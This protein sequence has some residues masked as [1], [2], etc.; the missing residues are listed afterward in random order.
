M[1]KIAATNGALA[2][3]P[4]AAPSSL[5]KTLGIRVRDARARHGMTRRMLA[6]DSRISERYLAELESGRGNLSIVLLKRLAAAIDVP[7]TELVDEGPRPPAE[8]L[9]LTQRLRRLTPD[10]LIQAA[11]LI[12]NRFGRSS[13]RLDR[14]ALVGLRGA[15]KTTLGKLL[16]T[17]L[18][19]EFVELSHAI[20]REAS[21]PLAEIFEF[22]GQAAYR[23]YEL[24][25]LES[26]VSGRRGIVLAA[27]GGLVAEAAS[28]ER[29]LDACYTVWVQASPQ[30]HWD[31]VLN[32]GDYRVR[33][34]TRDSEALADMRRILAQRESLYRMADARLD[35][36]SK[37]IS[38]ALKELV[39]LV[40]KRA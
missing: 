26:V 2:E 9:M 4:D 24:R 3:V 16:A 28:L 14:I 23:R 12:T 15:G 10:E 17:Q 40:A 20:E 22:G 1:R 19:W 13:N 39:K 37:T 5:L 34:G 30:E 31:R 8:Y 21:V 25:A 6:R 27:G 29:L 18:G 11:T 36:S 33:A 32:Q 38:Q 7:L 35:T